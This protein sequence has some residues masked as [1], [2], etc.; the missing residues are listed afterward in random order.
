[1]TQACRHGN[2]VC[3]QCV[4]VEDSGKRCHGIVNSYVAFMP[5]DQL[6]YSWLAIRL[7]D[8]GYDGNLYHS[9]RD[10]VRHQLDEFLCAYFAYVN[11]PN[12]FANPREAQIW[13]NFQRH[14]YDAGFRLADPD[15][16]S[17]GMD[18]I[19]PLRVE[20]MSH[21]LKILGSKK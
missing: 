20:D 5:F 8:G 4:V 12:G 19:T 1:M 14:V 15:A 6:K 13:L 18:L 3:S 10:A 2:L 16:K 9:K 11:A 17:G 21:Q 7:S